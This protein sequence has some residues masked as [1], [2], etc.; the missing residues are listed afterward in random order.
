MSAWYLFSTLGFYPI[1][2]GSTTYHIGSP[3]VTSA[4]LHLAG[5]RELKIET[6]GQSSVAKFVESVT[7]N[8]QPVE[9]WTIDHDQLITGGILQFNLT[10][11]PSSHL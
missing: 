10:D 9:D 3:S 1:A 8:G 7:F 4:T 2:P 6:T 11:T 5:G